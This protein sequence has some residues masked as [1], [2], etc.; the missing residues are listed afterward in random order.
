MTKQGSFCGLAE[1]CQLEVETQGTGWQMWN[2]F[3]AIVLGIGLH[4]SHLVNPLRPT[5]D[6][7]P[8]SATSQ[9]PESLTEA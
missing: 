3:S 2:S 1:S 9:R 4:V 8:D 5:P 7:S 6:L